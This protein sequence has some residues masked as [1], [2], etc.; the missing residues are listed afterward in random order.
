[1]SLYQRAENALQVHFERAADPASPPRLLAAMRHAVFS[2][3]ARIRPQLVMAVAISGGEKYPELTDAASVAIELMHCASLV[4][5]DMP[6]FDNADQRRG[7]PTVHKAFG[8]PLALLAGDGLIVMAYQVLLNACL[9]HPEKLAPL[10]QN[11]T[12]GVGLPSGIVAGQAWEC[13]VTADLSQYQR[14]KTGALFVA[15]TCAGA[16]VCDA[17]PKPWIALGMHL[18]EAYQVADDIR[19]VLG[20]AELLGK[21]TG[22]D[23][24]NG[25]PS[26]A[27]SLGLCGAVHYFEG[28]MDKAVASVPLCTC[29]ELMQDMVRREA[30]RLVPVETRANYR[31]AVEAPNSS[32]VVR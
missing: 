22:Q 14:A 1:M 21:P 27:S 9:M 8:E 26:S 6:A 16:M 12:S 5:D 7:K 13:E 17:D 29:R 15:S 25:R 23:V 4:H 18:G 20:Q 24:L 11:L 10:M 30:E 28:L 31:V 32:L 2:G 3:G 19:D